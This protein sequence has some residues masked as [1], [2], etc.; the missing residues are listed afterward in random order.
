MWNRTTKTLALLLFVTDLYVLK[1]VGN[2]GTSCGDILD[3]VHCWK[4]AERDQPEKIF[5]DCLHELAI[6]TDSCHFD[7]VGF[8]SDH[9][10]LPLYAE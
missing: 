4:A 3:D 7:S 2:E 8:M 10:W 5:D 6:R 1:I 9:L